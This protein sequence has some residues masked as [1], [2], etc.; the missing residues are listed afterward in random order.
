MASK[1]FSPQLRKNFLLHTKQKLDSKRGSLDKGFTLV[2]LIIVM[3]IVAILAAIALPLYRNQTIRAKATECNV[4]AGS[5]LTQ[6]GAEYS[7]DAGDA[8]TLLST[9]VGTET[10]SSK[11]CTFSTALT[12]APSDGIYT[13]AVA[14]KGDLEFKYAANG[15]INGNSGQKDIDYLTDATSTSALVTTSLQP[16]CPLTTTTTSTTP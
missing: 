8:Y 3:V 5:V 12:A 6:V 2:E 14:G 7:L 13:I 1:L 16:S 9:L 10:N 11:N 15:C 4:K